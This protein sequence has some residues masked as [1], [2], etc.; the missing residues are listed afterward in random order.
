MLTTFVN[1]KVL[2]EHGLGVGVAVVEDEP[3]L[4]HA[5]KA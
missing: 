2:V 1:L 4:L 5:Q 3:S